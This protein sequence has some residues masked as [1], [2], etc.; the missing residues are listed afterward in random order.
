MKNFN[1]LAIGLLSGLTVMTG[2]KDSFLEVES[3][4]QD[5]VETYYTTEEHISQSLVA[6]YS[7]MEWNDWNGSQYNPQ[8]VMSDIMGD[9]IY[10]GG[11]SATDNQYWH[12]MANY[13]AIPTNCMA[14]IW[15]NMYSGVKRSN[16]LIK[17]ANESRDVLTDAEYNEWTSEA[18]VLRAYYYNMLWKFYGNIPFYFE[19]LSAPFFAEQLQADQV[20]ENVIADLEEVLA[21]K[22]LPTKWDDDNLGRVNLYT[23]YML[24]AEM[25]MYQN[26]E[27]RYQ[28]ALGYMNEIISDSEYDLVADYASIWEST[29]EWSSESIFEVNYTDNMS[30]RGWGSGD[31]IIAGGTVFPRLCGCP[32]A[33]GE[34]GT[35]D[36]WGFAPVRAATWNM[37]AEGD[38]RREGSILDVRAYTEGNSEFTPRYENTGFWIGKYYAY[39]KNVARASGDKQLNYNNNLRIYRYAE[40]LLNAAE[41]LLKTGGAASTAT[42]YVNR[43]RTRAGVEALSNVT[44][45]DVLNER[46]LEFVGEGK[47]YWDL[48]R[49]GKAASVL[50]AS[51]EIDGLWRNKAWTADKKYLPIPY[52]EL[53]ADPNLTQ[54]PGY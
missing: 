23:G 27:S 31:A 6:A 50:V 18:R 51:N 3:H 28:K 44:V 14:G 11:Q 53:A 2:C 4:T 35:D 9:D 49:S 42:D 29:G 37:F 1:I 39:S 54:N 15:S 40:T 48:V 20:Y 24:Y 33:I 7:P 30:V 34:L 22:A 5:F 52:T 36:G 46:H 8:N 12:L 10:P 47:R 26:D 19:N 13:S 38:T 45:D 43:V 17:Y 32:Y 16:D 21:L 25:V 41:L